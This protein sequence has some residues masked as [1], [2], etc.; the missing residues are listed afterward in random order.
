MVHGPDKVGGAE[1]AVAHLEQ[2][3]AHLFNTG[4]HVDAGTAQLFGRHQFL[5]N[6][7]TQDAA[8]L[9]VLGVGG[10]HHIGRPE[11]GQAAHGDQSQQADHHDDTDG[12][13]TGIEPDPGRAGFGPF[14]Y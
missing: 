5:L 13:C 6:Q 12:D 8:T 11:V 4:R 14:A 9:F 3:A 7:F 1:V 2:I 10:L